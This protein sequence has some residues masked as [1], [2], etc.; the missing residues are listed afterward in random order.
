MHKYGAWLLLD[1][2]AE[3]VHFIIFDDQNHV[4]VFE[5]FWENNLN[6]AHVAC[7]EWKDNEVC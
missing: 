7:A 4:H 5:P 6:V 3:I 2:V 1:K